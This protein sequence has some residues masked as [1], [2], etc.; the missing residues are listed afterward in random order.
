MLRQILV[1]SLR[2]VPLDQLVPT[3]AVIVSMQIRPIVYQP[4]LVLLR[5][6]ACVL[7]VNISAMQKT[8]VNEVMN[9]VI[10][11]LVTTILSVKPMNHA[12]VLTVPM[13]VSMIKIIVLLLVASNSFVPRIQHNVIPID[14]HTVFHS[15]WTGMSMIQRPISVLSILLRLQVVRSIRLNDE[16]VVLQDLHG[17]Q[18]K[19]DAFQTLV[20]KDFSIV[21]HRKSV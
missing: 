5:L 9:H 10:L 12:T 18:S 15:V 6:Q 2:P 17:I 21:L 1:L 4:I 8:N 14:S 11:L 3:R 7:R 20:E 19:I 13:V 16:R